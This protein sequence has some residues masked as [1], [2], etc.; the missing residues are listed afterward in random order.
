MK[1][2][3]II[4]FNKSFSPFLGQ[5]RESASI[6]KE[7]ESIIEKDGKLVLGNRI[8]LIF[9]HKHFECPISAE[10]LINIFNFICLFGDNLPLLAIYLQIRPHASRTN[11]YFQVF[12]LFQ[13]ITPINLC[14]R[15]LRND[16]VVIKGNI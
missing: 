8:T 11:L 5:I 12:K 9:S 6:T 7:K 3:K 10:K 16:H 15:K 13:S 1:T 2:C 14:L 4:I